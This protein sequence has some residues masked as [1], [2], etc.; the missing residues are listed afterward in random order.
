MS[1]EK[2]A[3]IVMSVCLLVYIGSRFQDDP[4]S[5][6]KQIEHVEH[7]EQAKEIENSITPI[8]AESVHPYTEK[9]LRHEIDNRAELGSYDITA[10]LYRACWR[11]ANDPLKYGSKW[12]ELS[13]R[14]KV[15]IGEE[16]IHAIMNLSYHDHQNS[17][18]QILGKR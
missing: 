12:I 13:R 2:I 5:T 11:A 18:H 6:I 9:E 4:S 8:S 15:I 17:W 1:K 10:L 7:I 3:L 16:K 14:Y